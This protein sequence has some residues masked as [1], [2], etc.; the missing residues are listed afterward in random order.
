MIPRSQ[1]LFFGAAACLTMLA[2]RPA[3]AQMAVFDASNYA[4]LIKQAQTAL[5][6]LQQL[7]KQLTQ[8]E[9]L[10][11]SLNNP[12]NIASLATGLLGIQP[13]V[14]SLQSFANV[15]S[16]DFSSLGSAAARAGQIRA[17]S[18][19][20]SPQATTSAIQSFYDQ[21][22]MA[23][24]NRAAATQAA[25]EQAYTIATQRASGLQTLRDSIPAAADARAVADLNARIAAEAALIA[26]DQTRLQA[27]QLQ[28][29]SQNAQT[30]QA[31]AEEVA[32]T[33]QTR[34]ALLQSM[35][36]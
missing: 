10:Y 17:S 27:L 19:I 4:Q 25:S 13:V 11:S 28:V 24:G 8:A 18:Q 6:Q 23:S 20:Y 26:N 9:Q 15:A 7:Q 33:A 30:T 3:S 35:H 21:M 1:K 22:L 32:A 29:A 36:P 31:N 2:A 34:A 12:S 5:S 16:G 14:S